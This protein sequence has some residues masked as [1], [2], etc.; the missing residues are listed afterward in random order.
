MVAK[1]K[2]RVVHDAAHT[3]RGSRSSSCERAASSAH[4]ET[5]RRHDYANKRVKHYMLEAPE[6]ATVDRA[7]DDSPLEDQSLQQDLAIAAMV[8]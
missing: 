7:T 4:L 6:R 2:A 3:N 1:V 8:K 5:A